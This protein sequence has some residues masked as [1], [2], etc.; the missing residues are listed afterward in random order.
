M[1]RRLRT[2][3]SPAGE[4]VRYVDV[5]A[6]GRARVAAGTTDESR[7]LSSKTIAGFE[8]ISSDIGARTI[9]FGIQNPST[10]GSARPRVV[11]GAEPVWDPSQWAAASLGKR[12]VRAQI[13][14]AR[15]KGVT[16]EEW[17]PAEAARSDDVRHV[18]ADWLSRRGLP[19]LSFLADPFVLDAPAGRRFWIA[20]VQGRTVGYL[21]LI[22][23]DEAFVE[24]IIQH[25]DA[26]NG[27][28]SLLLDM[29]VKSLDEDTPFSLG[30]VPLS[31][32]APASTEAPSRSVRA[33]LAWVRAHAS[34][35]YNVEGLERFKAKYL[36]S[37][38]RTLWLVTD[39]AP[40]SLVTFYAVAAAFSD[41]RPISFVGKALWDALAEE[42]HAM[43]TSAASRLSWLRSGKSPGSSG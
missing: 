4:S 3:T 27:T 36:P 38:W 20:S 18:L 5:W 28:A 25:R 30:M 23:G 43:W 11:I 12:S 17:T 22:P 37:R 14:R 8:A 39:G 24:W 40:V 26:P 42:S 31:V 1:R 7:P 10:V 29:A 34:R 2:W 16:V 6:F 21:V 33:L 41:N 32:Y 19:P 35:F 15:A 9:W 13:A